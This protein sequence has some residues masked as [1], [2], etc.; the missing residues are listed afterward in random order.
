MSNLYNN[1]GMNG[2]Q[3]DPEEF[4]N[5][6]LKAALAG[7]PAMQLIVAVCYATAE[8]IK[9]DLKEAYAWNTI[10]HESGLPD[11][12]I[13]DGEKLHTRL[14]ANLT[15]T[16]IAIGTATADQPQLIQSPETT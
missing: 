13:E 10:A 7:H 3:P 14:Q 12:L 1:H 4:F 2:V 5:W 11:H 15:S 16:E 9:Q 6:V 8:G